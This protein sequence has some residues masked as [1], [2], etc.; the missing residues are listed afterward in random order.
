LPHV[1][2]LARSGGFTLFELLLVLL[3]MGMLY[4]WRCADAGSRIDGR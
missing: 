1:T 4:G 3:L 2:G